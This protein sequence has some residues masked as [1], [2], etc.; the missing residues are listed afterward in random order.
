ML[1]A[2]THMIL[3]RTV[4]KWFAT[5]KDVR[6]TRRK[7]AGFIGRT[8]RLRRGWTI[9]PVAGSDSLHKIAPTI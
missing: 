4:K 5:D 7:L 6:D 1:T 2:L 3:R 9:A 8:D